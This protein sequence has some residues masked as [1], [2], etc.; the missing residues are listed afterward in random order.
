[1]EEDGIADHLEV[2]EEE[3][4]YFRVWQGVLLVSLLSIAA[5][6]PNLVPGASAQEESG[7]KVQV[8]TEPVYPDLARRMKISGVVKVQLVVAPNGS[9]RETKVVGGH[10]LLANAVVDAVRR[11]RYETRPRETTESLEFRFDPNQ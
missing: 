10:P 2:R 11:W 1:V 5:M 4:V 3:T 9:V 6:A 7:R 8:K